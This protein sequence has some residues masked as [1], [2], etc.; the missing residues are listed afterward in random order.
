MLDPNEFELSHHFLGRALDMQLTPEQIEDVLT[1]PDRKS[2][3]AK[4]GT[5]NYH[6]GDLCF[7][8]NDSVS[9]RVVIT[10]VWSSEQAWARDFERAGYVDRAKAVGFGVTRRVVG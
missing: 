5:A 9:P 6:R 1:K 2:V 10:A 8:V 3:S 4:Y 7:G